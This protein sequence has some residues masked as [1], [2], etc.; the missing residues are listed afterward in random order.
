MSPGRR[1][2]LILGA[3]A[4]A[5]A[6][7]GGLVGALALQSHTGAAEL[8]S[9]SFPDLSG[10]PRRLTE[11][12]GRPL[13]CN[14]WAPWCAPCR[15]ELP[16]LDAVQRQH[17]AIGLQVVGIAVDNAVNVRQYLETVQIGFPV[18]VGNAGAIDLMRRLGNTAGGLP[19]TVAVDAAGRVRQRKLGA[20]SAAEL[21]A[22]LAG[23]LR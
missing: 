8:L 4:A 3:V 12:R 5:A 11:W 10:R 6:V 2:L 22:E 19:F 15:E 18:L 21:Q 9:S 17:A 14:F 20:Y 16:L 1:E 13:M 23:L 7:A